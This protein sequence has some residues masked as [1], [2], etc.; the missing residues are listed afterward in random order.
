LDQSPGFKTLTAATVGELAG[1]GTITAEQLPALE[2]KYGIRYVL[3][4]TLSSVADKFNIEARLGRLGDRENRAPFFIPGKEKNSLLTDQIDNLARRVRVAIDGDAGSGAATAGIAAMYGS[5]WRAFDLFHQGMTEWDKRQFGAARRLLLD[6]DSL[7]NGMP[8]ARYFLALLADYTGATGEALAH[9]RALTPLLSRFSLPFRL[10]T[11]ALQAKFDFDF[12]EQVRCLR[13]L[14]NMFP[15]SKEKTFELGEAYFRHGDATRAI[16]EYEAALAL[17]RNYAAALNHLGYCFSYLGRHRQAIECFERYRDIDR[18]AN[19]FDSLGDGYFYMGDYIQAEN[20]KIYAVSLDSSM[21]WPYLTVADIAILRADF[22]EAEKNLQ[23]Y[24]E[25]ASYPKAQADALAKK[26]FM[27]YLDD[28]PAAA[29]PLLEQALRRHDSTSISEHSAESHWLI[30]L[31]RIARGELPAAREELRWL[32]GLRDR[33]R[34]TA[35]N[36][37]AALKFCLHLEARIAEA[38][39]HWDQAAKLHRE[40]LAMKT[41]LSFWITG[42]SYPFFLNEYAEFC[43]RRRDLPG[44]GEAL[45]R[46]LAFNPNYTPALWTQAALLRAQGDTGTLDVLRRIAD[47]YGPGHERNRWRDR[48]AAELR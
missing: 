17:D 8:A 48:L 30:G 36:F 27:R 5:E 14:K 33:Y 32:R 35:G 29:L 47:I 12:A 41:Q 39:K 42:Y 7:A 3:R 23:R 38:E 26:A 2:K 25:L 20:S 37:D 15:F 43:L 34:L 18:T 1:G 24:Q 44:A 31:C 21:D 22:S 9:V 40:L 13:E 16:P 10:Q 4:G 28:D 19:S 46:C 11:R 6:A 45:G